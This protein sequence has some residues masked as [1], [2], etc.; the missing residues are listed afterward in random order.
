MIPRIDTPKIITLDEIVEIK[1]VEKTS[2]SSIN[3]PSVSICMNSSG[4]V[5]NLNCSEPYCNCSA[6]SKEMMP[7]EPEPFDEDL[8]RLK[9]ATNECDLIKQKLGEDWLGC[10]LSDPNDP[11]NCQCPKCG[12]NYWKYLAYT[13][14]NATFW[15]TDPK[16]PILRNAQMI[17]LAYQRIM[18]TVHGDSTTRPGDIVEIDVRN[19][20]NTIIKRKRFNGKWMV[21]KTVRVI[22]H[23]R[24]AMN[25]FLMRDT[26]FLE[27]VKIGGLVELS[28]E[29]ESNG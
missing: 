4:P 8:L 17:L 19:N 18:I 9:R 1:G 2:L 23:N 14:T 10:N 6:V 16:T 22:R 29:K 26:N 20:E 27:P 11:S 25:L 12:K 13:T 7:P 5:N 15:K 3:D 24:C 21:Y 28:K